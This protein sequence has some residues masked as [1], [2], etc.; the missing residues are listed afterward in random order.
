MVDSTLHVVE[1]GMADAQRDSRRA[2]VRQR[3]AVEAAVPQQQAQQARGGRPLEVLVKAR[4]VRGEGEVV[5]ARVERQRRLRRV[6]VD[7]LQ[8][9]H[10]PP[11]HQGPVALGSDVVG[12]DV[13]CNNS[14]CVM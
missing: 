10:R 12:A 8:R 3:R 11:V 7:V 1:A 14:M 6:P 13:S 2:F 5:G 4:K 9:L